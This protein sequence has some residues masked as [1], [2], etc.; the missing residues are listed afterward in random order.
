MMTLDRKVLKSKKKHV[1]HSSHA[2]RFIVS[3]LYLFTGSLPCIFKLKQENLPSYHLTYRGWHRKPKKK[4]MSRS[5][6]LNKY[7]P[8]GKNVVVISKLLFEQDPK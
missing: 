4:T 2:I 1:K 3:T 8:V 5:E 7:M 6:R